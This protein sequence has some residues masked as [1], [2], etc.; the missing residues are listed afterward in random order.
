MDFAFPLL[1]RAGPAAARP[2]VTPVAVPAMRTIIAFDMLMAGTFLVLI[3]SVLV[4]W[5]SKVQ[6]VKTWYLLLLTS[7]GYCLSFL[8]RIGHQTGPPP[9]LH[10]CLYSASLIYAAPPG[11]AAAALFFVIELHLRLSSALFS[12]RM[13]DKFIYWVAWGIPISHGVV[14]WTSL[15]IGLSDVTRVRR[16]PSG[17]YC[18]IVDTK[19]TFDG[20]HSCIISRLDA[21]HGSRDCRP[22]VPATRRSEND[23]G[24]RGRLPS[25]LV[26]PHGCIYSHRRFGHYHG[27]Y[28]HERFIKPYNN[29]SSSDYTSVRGTRIRYSEG[30]SPCLLLQIEAAK[31]LS[32]AV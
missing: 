17:A 1:R 11:A 30:A 21:H 12:K 19:N 9:P 7:A 20:D 22:L 26:H 32:D 8:I 10:F 23:A 27:R 28:P 2:V 14:F 18:H 29:P 25:A 3:M 15:T 6:R 5:F 16:D 4:A 13:S 24:K 31:G